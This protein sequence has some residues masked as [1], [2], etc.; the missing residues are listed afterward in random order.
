MQTNNH[1]NTI[2][3][4]QS[5]SNYLL[6]LSQDMFFQ[7]AVQYLQ[8]R[9]KQD[10]KRKLRCLNYLLDENRLLIY[11]RQLQ[12]APNILDLEKRPIIFHAEEK[13]VRLYW[14]NAHQIFF[15]QSRETTKTLNQHR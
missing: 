5:S 15:N 10:F 6:K 4:I 9:I 11:C 8:R 7:S 1:Q 14:D 3:D 2:E 12:Y 13:I